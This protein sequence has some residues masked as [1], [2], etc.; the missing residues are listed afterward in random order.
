MGIA[1]KEP[2]DEGREPETKFISKVRISYPSPFTF[3]LEVRDYS[4]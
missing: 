1:V 3:I 4:I 2:E